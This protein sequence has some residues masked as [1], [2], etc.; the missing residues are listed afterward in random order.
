[1]QL[2]R[3]YIC[4]RAFLFALFYFTARTLPSLV[5]TTLLIN[6][7]HLTDVLFVGGVY[8]RAAGRRLVE[9]NGWIMAA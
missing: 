6:T 5:I 4:I 8:L 7:S 9:L 2:M 3:K 1:M